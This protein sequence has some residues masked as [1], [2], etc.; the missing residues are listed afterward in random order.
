[1]G[2]FVPTEAAR[3][4]AQQVRHNVVLSVS[5]QKI[6]P[7]IVEL[8]ITLVLMGKLVTMELVRSL[9]RQ[10]RHNVVLSVS[11]RKTTLPTVELATMLAL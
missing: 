11:I 4:P 10:V 9:A 7:A 2:K 6:I 8:A 5:I 3:S 1:M